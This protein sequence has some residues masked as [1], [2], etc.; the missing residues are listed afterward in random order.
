MEVLNYKARILDAA[1]AIAREEGVAAVSIRAVALKADI[2]VGTV[3][4]YFPSKAELLFDVVEDFWEEAFSDVS[5]EEL[6]SQDFQHR[7]MAV[8]TVL[9]KRLTEYRSNWLEDMALLK[10]PDR[11]AGR[12]RMGSYD[13]KIRQRILR[14]MEGDAALDAYPWTETFTKEAFGTFLFQNLMGALRRKEKITMLLE[15]LDRI[16]SKA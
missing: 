9:E 5:V 14:L 8:Y 13:E 10:W 16:V 11:D 12:A 7:L 6:L 3:Y 2:A 15:V 1:K 4:N